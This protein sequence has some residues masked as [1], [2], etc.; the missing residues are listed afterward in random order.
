MR[1]V[2]TY[3]NQ[4]LRS[5][6]ESHFRELFQP[7]Q[8]SRSSCFLFLA[9]GA[10][11]SSCRG[12]QESPK[13]PGQTEVSNRSKGSLNIVTLSR[14]IATYSEIKVEPVSS[15]TL[16]FVIEATGQLQANASA[17]TRISAPVS[18]KVNNI[19]VSLGEVV[20]SGQL[21][22]LDYKPGSWCDD[23]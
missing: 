16:S 22:A 5:R 2:I 13:S 12:L 7:L 17:V 20:R 18:G 23:H 4:K 11:L 1:S 3:L 6:K 19:K 14:E 8:N 21:L 9:I 10:L 15:R